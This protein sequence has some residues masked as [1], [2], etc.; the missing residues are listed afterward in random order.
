MMLEGLIFDVDGVLTNTVPLHYEAW[1][2]MFTEAGYEFDPDIYREKVD[3]K[4]R[5]DGVRGV[6]SDVSEDEVARAGDVKQSYYLQLLETA[7]LEPFPDAAR[8]VTRA[9]EANLQL[10]AASGSRNAPTVLRKIG[11][12]DRLDAIVTGADVPRGK[13]EPDIFLAA[14]A[15]MSLDASRCVVFEDAEAGV[16]AAK[17]GGFSCV[18]V[19]R[20][21]NGR[22]LEA[23]DIVV[24]NLD[25]IDL[26]ELGRLR[27]Q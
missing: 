20:D 13:P 2:R 4:S 8:L 27:Q 10:A 17:R 11:L 25:L 14:A 1:R 19:D 16:Q 3:G 6:M 22:F 24:V 26:D 15:E 9:A 23:A 12:I 7:D 5:L 18:G 21:G